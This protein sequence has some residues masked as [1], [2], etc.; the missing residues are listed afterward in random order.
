MSYE[1]KT[2]RD[3]ILERAAMYIG[4]METHEVVLHLWND[5]SKTFEKEMVQYVPAWFKII[6]EVIVNAIDHANRHPSG[7]SRVS[8]IDIHFE[9]DGS[10]LVRNNGPAIP[11]DKTNKTSTGET[12]YTPTMLFGRVRSGNNWGDNRT[13]GGMNGIGVKA[14]NVMSVWFEVTVATGKEKFVQRFENNMGLECEPQIT[15]SK[16]KSHV[17]VRFMPDYA[18]FGIVDFRFA[19]LNRLIYTRAIQSAIC[20]KATIWYNNVLLEFDAKTPMQRFQQYANAFAK[21]VVCMELT[22]TGGP[23]NNNQP[24]WLAV[25]YSG[26]SG[27]DQVSLINGIDVINGGKH[28]IEFKKQII[29]FLKNK[30]EKEVR[31]Y[32]KDSK[33][34][35]KDIEDCL[36]FIFKGCVINPEFQSQSK[37]LLTNSAKQFANYIINAKHLTQIWSLLQEDIVNKFFKRAQPKEPKRTKVENIEKYFPARKA[38]H[39]KEWIQSMLF[40]CEGDSAMG[41]AKTGITS[42]STEIGWDYFGIYSIQGVPI[43]CHKQST[44]RNDEII[45]SQK[46]QGNER[47]NNLVKILG[48]SYEKK[49]ELDEKG[50]DEFQTLRYGAVAILVDQD[51]DGYNIYGLLLTFFYRFWPALF[52]RNYFKK[53]DTPI[54]RVYADKRRG[55]LQ[56]EFYTRSQYDEWMSKEYGDRAFPSTWSIVYY[57]GLASH[58]PLETARLFMNFYDKV[59]HIESDSE[60]KDS[61]EIYYGKDTDRRKEELKSPCIPQPTT[62][63]MKV[64]LVLK[65]FVKEAQRYNILRKLVHVL[66]GMTLAKR[67]VLYAARHYFGTSNESRRVS[68]FAGDVQSFSQYHHGEASLN[69]TI[70]GMAQCFRGAKHIPMLYPEGNFGNYF[71]RKNSGSPRYVSVRLNKEVCFAVF[72]VRDDPCLDYVFDEGHRCEPEY[73]IPVL[74]MALLEHVS[75]P[76]TGWKC[77][78][79][80]RD[81]QRVLQHVESLI[82]H[83]PI[84]NYPMSIWRDHVNHSVVKWNGK[85]YSVGKYILQEDMVVVTDLP[86]SIMT[87]PFIEGIQKKYADILESTPTDDSLADGSKVWIELRFK[88]NILEQV[89]EGKMSKGTIELG[90]PKSDPMIDFLNLYLPLTPSLNLIGPDRGILEYTKYEQILLKWYSARK[91]LYAVRIERELVLLRM[92]AKYLEN[93][94]RFSKHHERYKITS[95]MERE[96]VDAILEKENYVRFNHT[97]LESPKFYSADYLNKNIIGGSFDYLMNLRYSDLISCA[98]IKREEKLKQVYAEILHLE[99][100]WVEVPSI[101]RFTGQKTWLEEVHKAS[102]LIQEGLENAWGIHYD[103]PIASRKVRISCHKDLKKDQEM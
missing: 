85:I 73:Y 10:V 24:I 1:Q 2:E 74:P 102:K 75:I 15:L 82:K 58:S 7:A 9:E 3:H 4:S 38:G 29:S 68:T 70:I 79:W 16:E 59:I 13:G 94:I 91:S 18:R 34:S 37:E 6:D 98:C 86:I 100:D 17:Q 71:N 50:S 48:L 96:Q 88:K 32:V 20:S 8:R 35:T 26:G 19:L 54:I 95:R 28:L 60:I 56:Q 44:E 46:L 30:L 25:A 90:H 92:K 55:K 21:P 41:A 101:D 72:P 31:K 53:L 39:K 64:T 40:I 81:F 62:R 84:A 36:F 99:K 51:L 11:V 78:I 97:L 22:E 33:V 83:G 45:R 69:Q 47:I 67:K 80:A 89:M 61:I 12:L 77:Q 87:E 57:K 43:N 63:F 27:F 93:I 65:C 103:L 76:G 5:V 14:T 52:K 66:D 49:Y 23:A 42:Q